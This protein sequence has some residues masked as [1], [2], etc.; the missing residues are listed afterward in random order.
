M[1]NRDIEQLEV[2]KMRANKRTKKLSLF[3]NVSLNEISNAR[4]KPV[5]GSVTERL[6]VS[7]KRKCHINGCPSHRAADALHLDTDCWSESLHITSLP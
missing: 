3:L 6:I 5:S 7:Q 4:A 1:C 2:K